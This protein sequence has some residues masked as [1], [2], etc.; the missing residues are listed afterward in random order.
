MTLPPN[1]STNLDTAAL[2]IAA[3]GWPVFPL[4]PGSKLPAI[5]DWEHRATTDPER[6]AAW[7]SRGPYN[8]GIACG[9]AGL[10]VLDL[11]AAHGHQPPRGWPEEVRHGRDV[12]R[13]LAREAGEPD[14]VD[15][16]TVATPSGGEHRYFLTPPDQPELRNTTGDT[17]RGLGWHI[18][19]RAA[20]GSITAA[21]SLRFIGRDLRRYRATRGR[22]PAPPPTWLYEALSGR[23]PGLTGPTGTTRPAGVGGATDG[24]H[25]TS[26]PLPPA[27]RRLEAY[28]QAALDDEADAVTRAEPG[29][30]ATTLFR[31]AAHL[32]ELVGSGALDPATLVSVLR[33]A[34]SHHIGVDDWTDQ[35]ARH[36]IANGM[37]AGIKHPR[38]G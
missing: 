14:P 12:L 19:T 33:H 34:A 5:R 15:T 11:D 9:P 24:P 23:S 4:R 16:Y 13:L 27:G 6:I 35:E 31:A 30:R 20:G 10:V 26:K 28:V 37:A 18:D 8:I 7:W 38:A 3:R 1:M 32:G 17:G 2:R 29:T 21:G 22:P 36:H 25:R